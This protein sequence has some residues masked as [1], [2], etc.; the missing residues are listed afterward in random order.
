MSLEHLKMISRSTIKITCQTKTF[1]SL[2]KKKIT[3]QAIKV[4]SSFYFLT[5]AFAA[6]K[7]VLC[8][9]VRSSGSLVFRKQTTRG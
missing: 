8:T 9:L 7:V 4:G 3:Y 5:P 2:Q 1:K 6:W